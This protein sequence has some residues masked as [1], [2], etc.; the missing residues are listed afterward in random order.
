[1][2]EL[3]SRCGLF[4]KAYQSPGFDCKESLM[5]LPNPE[6]SHWRFVRPPPSR[7]ASFAESTG[8]NKFLSG[9]G[10]HNPFKQVRARV[11]GS[12][13]HLAVSKNTIVKMKGLLVTIECDWGATVHEPVLTRI[14]SLELQFHWVPSSSLTCCLPTCY[15]LPKSCNNSWHF[16]F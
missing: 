5:H 16:R 4:S 8:R 13:G 10:W 9:D 11:Q 12:S 3:S 7:P 15:I 2:R 14:Q 6:T 1:M